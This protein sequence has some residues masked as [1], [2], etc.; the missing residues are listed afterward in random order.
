LFITGA[1]TA[2]W[3]PRDG[4]R[5][6]AQESAETQRPPHRL[7]NVERHRPRRATVAAADPLYA[8]AQPSD[9][10]PSDAQPSDA[11]PSDTQLSDAQ[12]ASCQPHRPSHRL[13]EPCLCLRSLDL[14]R[15]PRPS[16]IRRNARRRPRRPVRCPR[17]PRQRPTSSQVKSILSP[18][19]RAKPKTNARKTGRRMRHCVAKVGVAPPGFEVRRRMSRVAFRVF[20]AGRAGDTRAAF[21]AIS[22]FVSRFRVCVCVYVVFCG[23]SRAA[24]ESK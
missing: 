12:P 15:T 23:R 11:Q 4:V 5:P 6:H 1:P 14:V 20:P 7:R 16:A 10:Q 18:K 17:C 13:R 21:C 19:Q 3:V 8:H 22:C 2:N 9:A 24:Q